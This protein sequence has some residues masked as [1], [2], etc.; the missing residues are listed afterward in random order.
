LDV[1]TGLE[2]IKIC[3]GYELDGERYDHRPATLKKMARCV[4]IYEEFPG[5]EEDI[6]NATKMDQLPP[7]T[8]K[9]LEAIEQTVNIPISIVSVGPGRNETILVKDPFQY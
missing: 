2:T 4:P 9:Y 6:S 3:T 5:W 7:K 8:R 1:L